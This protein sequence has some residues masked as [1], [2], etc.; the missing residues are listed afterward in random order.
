MNKYHPKITTTAR[1]M[2]CKNFVN[3]RI[4]IRDFLISE[5]ISGGVDSTEFCRFNKSSYIRDARNSNSLISGS[6]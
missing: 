4:G 6:S 3:D 5:S 2:I 1:K